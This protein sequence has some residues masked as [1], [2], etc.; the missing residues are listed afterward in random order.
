MH[1]I[2]ISSCH[3]IIPQSKHEK[4]WEVVSLWKQ[5]GFELFH[6]RVNPVEEFCIFQLQ[7]STGHSV[8]DANHAVHRTPAFTVSSAVE[9]GVLLITANLL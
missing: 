9:N 5:C 2:S 3:G 1:Q 4:F 6:S 8:C 7:T